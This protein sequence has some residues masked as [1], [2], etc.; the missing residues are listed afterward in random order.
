MEDEIRCYVCGLT[1]P[2]EQFN[3]R[4]RRIG[5]RDS[6]CRS[7]RAVYRHEH[8]SRNK[9][10][11]IDEARERK[12]RLTLER[13]RYLFAYFDT[14]PCTDCGESD[15]AVL[16]FDHLRDKAFNIGGALPYRNWQSI[17]DEIAKCE[18]VCANCHRRRTARRAGS[19]R[20]VLG[21]EAAYAGDEN[22]TRTKTLEGS[23]AAF[24]PRPRVRQF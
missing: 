22:R 1:K 18:V 4:R 13:T 11:Y 8:Y 20:A 17:L 16:E 14:H 9:Q 10:R 15:P 24:T 23:Y 2:A 21:D 19:I 6:H 7:C 3:W 5:Q 12:Q